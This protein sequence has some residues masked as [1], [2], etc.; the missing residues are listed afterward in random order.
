[1]TGTKTLTLKKRKTTPAAN[2]K[3]MSV[4]SLKTLTPNPHS[5]MT[6]APLRPQFHQPQQP[7][8]IPHRHQ[9]TKR[10]DVAQPRALTSA[11]HSVPA[12]DLAAQPAASTTA[13][14]TPAADKPPTTDASQ[15][16]SRSSSHTV[17]LM[18]ALPHL[19]DIRRVNGAAKGKFRAAIP[20]V[21]IH[22]SPGSARNKSVRMPLVGLSLRLMPP[23][24][25]GPSSG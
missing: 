22:C 6:T 12:T 13:R 9:L 11:R 7:T 25:A 20:P 19:C 3:R 16:I 5:R 4:Q 24:A 15:I 10:V 18:C 17:F 23:S 1:M 2:H 21:E 8:T 14:P